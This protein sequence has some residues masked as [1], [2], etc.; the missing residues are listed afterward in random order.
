MFHFLHIEVFIF[1]FS[2]SASYINNTVIV[3]NKDIVVIGFKKV[4]ESTVYAG[5]SMWDYNQIPVQ[6]IGQGIVSTVL[7]NDTFELVNLGKTEIYLDTPT[8]G[9]DDS[10]FLNT[11]ITMII[12]R[13]K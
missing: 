11:V 2:V 4:D 3:K 1:N 9:E 7:P 6:L 8:L 12:Q 5:G 10:L 13:L